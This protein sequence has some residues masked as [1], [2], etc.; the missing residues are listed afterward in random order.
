MGMIEKMTP[1]RFTRDII[2]DLRDGKHLQI[3]ARKGYPGMVID[4]IEDHELFDY[5]VQVMVPDGP[6]LRACKSDIEVVS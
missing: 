6:T 1:V 3:L 4:T 2:E 5:I